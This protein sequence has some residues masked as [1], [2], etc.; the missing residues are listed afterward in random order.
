MLVTFP[1]R[2]LVTFVYCLGQMSNACDELHDIPPN[3][4]FSHLDDQVS[5]CDD[6]LV[7]VS[8][9]PVIALKY[10]ELFKRIRDYDGEFTA[11]TVLAAVASIEKELS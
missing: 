10:C 6:Q 11:D 5:G 3:N 7:E 8:I 2:Y 1:T 9:D 4:M